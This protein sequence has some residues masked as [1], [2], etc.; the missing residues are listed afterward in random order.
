MAVFRCEGRKRF[1]DDGQPFCDYEQSSYWRGRCPGCGRLYDCEKVGVDSVDQ[2]NGLT[3]LGAHKSKSG[4][5]RLSTGNEGFDFVLS[6]GL[7]AGNVFLLGGFPNVG[8]TTLLLMVADYIAKTQGKVIYAS[9]EES[10]DAV[11]ERARSL[12]LLND[13][14]IVLGNQSTVE[15]VIEE[16]KKIKAFLVIWDSAQ[17]FISHRAG[18]SP[19][20]QS[21]CKAIGKV[22]KDY[23]GVTKTCAIIVNQMTNQ[24]DLKGGTELEH[25][26]DSINVFAFPKE[27][28]EQAPG[29]AEEGY[30][31]LVNS[32]NRNGVANRK[33]YFCMTEE[34]RLEH[35]EARSKL[36]AFPG[37]GKYG[38]RRDRD[39]EDAD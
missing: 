25:K 29:S 33:T 36:I 13:R 20:S 23:C 5:Q 27:D 24:G 34:G 6:G 18:G 30:R 39:E 8:K 22:I 16:A 15:D 7:L 28:D 2:S 21:Q 37:K 14:V 3:T 17:E 32:K 4:P 31:V 19:G 26:C 10:A 35:V 38:K 12:D 1:D 9:G 11:N